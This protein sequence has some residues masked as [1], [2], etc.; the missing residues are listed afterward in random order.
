MRLLSAC[1]IALTVAGCPDYTRK[2]PPD[3]SVPPPN[4]DGSF[5]ITPPPPLPDAK[6]KFPGSGGGTG[7]Y[8]DPGMGILFLVRVD[9]SA[10]NLAGYYGD[11]IQGIVSG[12]KDAGFTISAVALGSLYEGELFWALG[13]SFG[14]HEL[15]DY[16]AQV[17]PLS[18]PLICPTA[19]L[20]AI[21]SEMSAQTVT[22]PPGYDI[23]E[24]PFAMPL[25]AFA[26]VVL[27]HG[28][29]AVSH[30]DSGCLTGGVAPATYFAGNLQAQWLN[31][32]GA[33]FT[34]PRL[35]TRFWFLAT[36]EKVSYTQERER[37]AAVSTFPRDALDAIEPSELEFY[38]PLVTRMNNDAQGLA[39]RTHLCD[40]LGTKMISTAK[41]F[42]TEWINQMKAAAVT[43]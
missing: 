10:V 27:D 24:Y 15:L 25:A 12:M 2:Q 4:V 6:P 42:A 16:E 41:T 20:A 26:V 36:D 19:Q 9:R 13:S 34:L 35:Q 8:K 43:P 23:P 5:P 17:G 1:V 37:C 29:R 30:G 39:T 32:G 11:A 33:G 14:L 28:D 7:A 3:A 18:A 21:S 31:S 38:G 40:A 22:Y